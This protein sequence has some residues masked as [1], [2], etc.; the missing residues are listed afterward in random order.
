MRTTLILLAVLGVG[1]VGSACCAAQ[2]TCVAIQTDAALIADSM[3]RMSADG[4]ELT[5]MRTMISLDLGATAM[6][7]QAVMQA[8]HPE[9]RQFARDVISRRGTEQDKLLNWILDLY[10]DG[11]YSATKLM[12]DDS[13]VVRRFALCNQGF[14]AGY[15]LAM[16]RHD[17]GAVAI[18]RQA[19]AQSVHGR[20]GRAASDV[21][22]TRSLD[23]A[24]LQGWLACWC[25]ITVSVADGQCVPCCQ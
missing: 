14:D 5:F 21:I 12:P 8:M 7:R 18:A 13:A 19:R 2:C 9:L 10:G 15:M 4:A 11:I 22:R 17:A 20:I 3:Q 24:R 6:S 23:I 1:C 25:G 16:I